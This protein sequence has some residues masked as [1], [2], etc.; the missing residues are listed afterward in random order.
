MRETLILHRV[1]GN[2]NSTL[3]RDEAE[4]PVLSPHEE[5]G[6]SQHIADPA[7]DEGTSRE[8]N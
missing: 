4:M 8:K 3:R 2:S 5:L 7:V 6:E 1:E